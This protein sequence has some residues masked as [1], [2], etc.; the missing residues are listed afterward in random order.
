[1]KSMEMVSQHWPR[2]GSE[3]KEEEHIGTRLCNVHRKWKNDTVK[4]VKPVV[5]CTILSLDTVFGDMKPLLDVYVSSVHSVHY[6]YS[7]LWLGIVRAK[8]S[9]AG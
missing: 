9:T 2:I 6:N 5:T 7:P 1:M 8:R 4:K 3:P